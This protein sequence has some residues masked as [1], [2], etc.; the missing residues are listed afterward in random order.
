MPVPIFCG[1]SIYRLGGFSQGWN[2]PKPKLRQLNRKATRA[3]RQ[4]GFSKTCSLKLGDC[5][6][7]R[8]GE[9]VLCIVSVV[10]SVEDERLFVHYISSMMIDWIVTPRAIRRA[11]SDQSSGLTILRRGDYHCTRSRQNAA[12]KGPSGR[13]QLPWP[14]WCPM[15]PGR[16]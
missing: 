9:L 7:H 16:P 8:Q 10:P 13:A 12:F 4:P 2:Y 15:L 14:K 6:E 3:G 1:A 5:T 11:R